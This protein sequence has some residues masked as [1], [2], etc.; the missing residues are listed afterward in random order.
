MQY[1]GRKY[2]QYDYMNDEQLNDEYDNLALERLNLLRGDSDNDR[3]DN[4]KKRM[5][6]IDHIRKDKRSYNVSSFMYCDDGE[7][8][9]ITTRKGGRSQNNGVLEVIHYLKDRKKAIL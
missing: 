6:Y 2:P 4:V 8:V 5:D 9:R 3:L 1:L 7:T